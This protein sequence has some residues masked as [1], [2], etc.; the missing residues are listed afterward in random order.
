MLWTQVKR[1]FRPNPIWATVQMEGDFD[2]RTR[3]F[4]QAAN[5]FARVPSSY[6]RIVATLRSRKNDE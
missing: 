3:V 4:Y 5:M 6:R 2:A 1:R